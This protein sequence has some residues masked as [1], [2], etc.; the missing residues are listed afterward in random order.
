MAWVAPVLMVAGQTSWP[1]HSPN[2]AAAA[3]VP[4]ATAEIEVAA[5]VT[6]VTAATDQRLAGV[7]P[8]SKPPLS[9]VVLHAR[10]RAQPTIAQGAVAIVAR[11]TR[12][13]ASAGASPGIAPK[14]SSTE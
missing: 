5:P 4:S 10:A 14:Q 3:S 13:S 2:L 12:A 1:T 6:P 11:P 9:D 8:S 7:T